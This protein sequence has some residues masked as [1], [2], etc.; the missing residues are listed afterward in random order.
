MH[1]PS[2]SEEGDDASWVEELQSRFPCC[3]CQRIYLASEIFQCDICTNF[4]CDTCLRNYGKWIH[5]AETCVFCTGES[6]DAHI[7]N[8]V[9]C[10]LCEETLYQINLA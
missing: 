1:L 3:Q 8:F 6:A 9:C 7:L 2:D 5:I 10:S 4:V